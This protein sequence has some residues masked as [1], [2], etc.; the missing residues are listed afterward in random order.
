MNRNFCVSTTVI[1][2]TSLLGCGKKDFRVVFSALHIM[3]NFC[4]LALKI[5]SEWVCHRRSEAAIK[6][7]FLGI[8]IRL[9]FSIYTGSYNFKICA[10]DGH[11]NLPIV[12]GNDVKANETKRKC[13]G[14]VNGNNGLLAGLKWR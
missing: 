13:N 11:D 9:D 5:G 10:T 6:Y 7:E 12:T 4:S 14:N 3:G 2:S 1:K 8:V